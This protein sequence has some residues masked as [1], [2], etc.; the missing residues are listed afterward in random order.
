MEF[1]KTLYPVKTV[2]IKGYGERLIAGE[3]LEGALLKDGQYV[4]SEA[5]LVDEE[6]FFYVPDKFLR[7]LSKEA[8][9]KKVEEAL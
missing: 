7:M 6:I 1:Q 5:R 4:S 8:L 3:S 2:F 9:A